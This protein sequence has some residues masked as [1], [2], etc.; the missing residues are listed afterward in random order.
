MKSD[1]SRNILPTLIIIGIL[2]L[3]FPL[4]NWSPNRIFEKTT[5]K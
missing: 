2:L 3:K 1:F 4:F 5:R